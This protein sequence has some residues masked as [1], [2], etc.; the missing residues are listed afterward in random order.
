[1][2]LAVKRGRISA[3]VALDILA[4]LAAERLAPPSM[5]SSRSISTRFSGSAV[6]TTRVLRNA[7]N[8]TSLAV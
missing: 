3:D 6:G 7:V 4:E 8:R 5:A 2:G 1:M